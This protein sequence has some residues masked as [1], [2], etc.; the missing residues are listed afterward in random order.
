MRPVRRLASIIVSAVAALP[1]LVA[2]AAPCLAC[3]CVPRTPGE[4]VEDSDVVFVGEVVGDRLVG[5]GTA[6]RF[7][8]ERVYAG[9]VPP[10]VEVYADIGPGAV[11]S[12]AVL[13]A[14]GDR[15]AVALSR[16]ETG[17]Y[18]YQTSGCSLISVGTLER[19]AGEGRPPDP[20]AT[21]PQI[22]PVNEGQEP[23]WFLPGWAIVALGAT[24]ALGLMALSIA[25]GRR[26]PAPAPAL[27]EE[28][29]P[30]GRDDPP[31]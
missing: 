1:L 7:R 4:V 22:A 17:P 19:I 5:D 30:T 26:G 27:P 6:Q 11:S 31:G 25:R 13:F 28:V 24:L 21:F 15:V 2:G 14:P 20:S 12:C 16:A 3:D 8:V 23:P 9:A 10:E 18:P 29:P